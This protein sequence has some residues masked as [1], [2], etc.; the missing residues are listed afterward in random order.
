MKLFVGAKALVVHEG[1]VL[2]VRESG[3]YEEGLHEGK[4]DVPG[5]RLDDG[6]SFFDG[7]KREVREEAGLEVTPVRVVRLA[8][9]FPE[10]K[11]EK[12][13]IIRIYMECELE[14]APTVVLSTDHDKFEW[15]D[16][17]EH[18]KYRLVD[19]PTDNVHDVMEEYINLIKL[20]RM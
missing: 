8:E 19:T 18:E 20:S 4:W 9:N 6:E 12:C 3:D 2:I 16:P 7:L 10:I 15:I 14:A 17:E 5:G 1:K 13:H 11:G